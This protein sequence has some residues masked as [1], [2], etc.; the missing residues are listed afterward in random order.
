MD[1]TP[2][3]DSTEIIQ[4]DEA[5]NT[6][7]AYIAADGNREIKPNTTILITDG[8]SAT[9][10]SDGQ[11]MDTLP[12]GKHAL[13][14]QTLPLLSKVKDL[15]TNQKPIIFFVNNR[16]FINL[17]WLKNV[18]AQLG[19]GKTA[20]AD[21]EGIFSF[22][23]ADP[24]KFLTAIGGGTQP[25]NTQQVL[26]FF[27]NKIETELEAIFKTLN[28]D[29]KQLENP[30]PLLDT[31]LK[32]LRPQFIQVGVALLTV[33]IP[34]EMP[35]ENTSTTATPPPQPQ[36]KADTQTTENKTDTTPK[37]DPKQENPQP[38]QTFGLFEMLQQNMQT[39][40][41]IVMQNIGGNTPQQPKTAQPK[42]EPK[43]KIDVTKLLKDLA[44]LHKDG[45]ITDAEFQEEKS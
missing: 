45:I 34:A 18:E 12:A 43:E 6:G 21:V 7:L 24:P 33:E 38:K 27:K 26:D 25:I 13:N 10:I 30:V 11:V 42:P 35:K 4:W 29:V 3:T 22:K 39:N 37:T 1:T 16:D 19:G 20:K 36:P 28:N 31:V 41:N 23:I 40:A 15:T 8:Q 2:N 17:R 5:K 44:Q 32:N 14:P 9:F